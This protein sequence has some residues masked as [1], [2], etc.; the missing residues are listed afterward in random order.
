ML[1]DKLSSSIRNHLMHHYMLLEVADIF[2]LLAKVQVLIE[3]IKA[4]S[5]TADNNYWMS[6][7]KPFI[8]WNSKM[9]AKSINMPEMELANSLVIA[10][11]L[12]QL[13][14][15]QTAIQPDSILDRELVNAC[16]L[17]LKVLGERYQQ[18]K[19]FD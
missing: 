9:N 7:N 19:Y 15:Y 8:E 17:H 14:E 3:K 2:E 12:A 13:E 18:T 16:A 4:N 6:L 5:S 10:H 11:S 1:A